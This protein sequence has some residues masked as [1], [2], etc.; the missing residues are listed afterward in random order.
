FINQAL[1]NEPITIFGDGKQTRSFCFVSDEVEGIYRLMTSDI[2][3]PVNIGNPLEISILQ[4]AE[5]IIEL[6]N[7]KSEIV[8]KP[9]PEDD[10]KV[11][12]P[13]I[14]KAK[15]E[16]DWEP[17]VE[18]EEGLKKTIEYFKTMHK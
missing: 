3:N 14:A 12:R 1:K 5:K 13:D 4:L 16:L 11:R 7:S 6:T 8:F 9:L 17:K 15:K 2:N 18:L 10:P